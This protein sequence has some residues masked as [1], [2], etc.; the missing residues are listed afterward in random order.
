MS[1]RA[2]NDLDVQLRL[3]SASE[4]AVSCNVGLGGF[5]VMSDSVR[6]ILQELQVLGLEPLQ[7]E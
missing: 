5:V 7:R 4:E 1:L 2:P 3:P 6:M